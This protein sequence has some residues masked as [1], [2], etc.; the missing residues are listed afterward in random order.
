VGRISVRAAGLGAAVLAALSALVSAYWA[1]GGTALLSTVGG[2]L[3]RL[4]REGGSAAVLVLVLTALAKAA[5]VV[6]ALALVR[7]P[8]RVPAVLL[9][10]VALVTGT[11]LAGYGGVL[12]AVGVVALT[13]A[14]GPVAD[15]VAL[16]WHA[17]FWDPWFLAWGVLLL[18]AA[19]GRRRVRGRAAVRG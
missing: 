14:L 11:L 4:G 17:L 8:A 9:E 19:L 5:G 3:E 18:A 16:R 2:D 1:A 10:R 15:P 13:G 6:L 7:P 12:T